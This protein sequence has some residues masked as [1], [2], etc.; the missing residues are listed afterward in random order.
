MYPSP[1]I[2]GRYPSACFV[3]AR[4]LTAEV[5]TVDARAMVG[6][7]CANNRPFVLSL[8]SEAQVTR[9]Y[10]HNN[11]KLLILVLFIFYRIPLITLCFTSRMATTIPLSP[12]VYAE[13]SELHRLLRD[14]IDSLYSLDSQSDHRTY[15]NAVNRL[16]EII[17][18]HTVKLCALID[19]LH[20]KITCQ[21]AWAFVI[22]VKLYGYG[23]RTPT[24]TPA[25]SK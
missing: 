7:R 15:E 25:F 11:I 17:R 13:S 8:T 24:S 10:H 2:R 23:I 19:L 21:Q 20:S 4:L 18:S 5:A 14:T 22:T 16:A 9:S 3:R 1:L 6:S 12:D